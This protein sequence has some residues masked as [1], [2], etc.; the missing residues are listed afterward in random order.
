VKSAENT[1]LIALEGVSK[2]YD[3]PSGWVGDMVA[4][5][6]GRPRGPAGVRAVQDVDLTIYPGEVVGIVGESGCGKSS[7]GRIVAGITEPTNGV[8]RYRGRD[9]SQI[10]GAERVA[11]Q[12]KTQMIFQDPASS[13]DGRMRI[14]E[15]I[16]EA[17]LHHRLIARRDVQ[18]FVDRQ[19]SRVNLPVEYKTR[20]PHEFSGGQRQRVGIARALAVS[21]EIIV[22]DESVSALDVSIQA[23]IIN[24]FIDMRRELDL[25]YMF[26][27]HDLSVVEH[28]SDRV[29][30]MYLGRIVE[31]ANTEDL[32]SNPNHP[33]TRALLAQIPKLSGVKRRFTAIK[34]E[35]P[36]PSNPPSGCHFHTRC[37][38][39]MPICRTVPPVLKPISSTHSSA[40]HLNND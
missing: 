32:F 29:A 33:Y 20:F 12:L 39:V 24:L 5:A 14:G 1:P 4:K 2:I 34:G 30:V 38:H 16:A 11:T 13:L 10:K 17:P 37:P 18:D 28:I 23:Q 7:L 9:L 19:L 40:C 26:I 15:I 31:L 21:P 6:L 3:V 25:T 27:S 8:V 36:S 22:C 35:I